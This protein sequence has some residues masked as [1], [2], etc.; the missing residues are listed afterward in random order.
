MYVA[1]PTYL[2]D[3]CCHIVL[4]EV[5]T[6]IVTV[7]LRPLPLNKRS[8]ERPLGGRGERREVEKWMVGEE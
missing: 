8:E 6:E 4:N 5:E 2:W 7:A 1:L 3:Q